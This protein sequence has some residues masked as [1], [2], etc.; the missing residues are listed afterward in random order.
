MRSVLQSEG[1]VSKEEV[2]LDYIVSK[3]HCKYKFAEGDRIKFC[4]NDY[5]LGVSNGTMGTIKELMIS[6]TDVKFQILTDDGRL[7]TISVTADVKM[8]H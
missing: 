5:R 1:K 4:K 7:V 8:T 2:E 3:H 6:D